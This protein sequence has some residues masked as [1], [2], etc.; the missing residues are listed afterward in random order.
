MQTLQWLL[1]CTFICSCS[2]NANVSKSNGKELYKWKS[3]PAHLRFTNQRYEMP[4]PL[5]C[6]LLSNHILMVRIY[7]N[8]L[9]I[10][11]SCITNSMQWHTTMNIPCTTWKRGWPSRFHVLFGQFDGKCEYFPIRWTITNHLFVDQD[12]DNTTCCPFCMTFF[13]SF[14][15]K[16]K[17]QSQVSGEYSNGSE[18]KHYRTDQFIFTC[19]S[20]CNL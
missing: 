17:H 2:L 6:I 13:D 12:D 19:C 14:L 8:P 18:D 15:K 7:T 20:K 5:W 9:V 16:V 3:K 10:I 1:W 4:V 11:Y